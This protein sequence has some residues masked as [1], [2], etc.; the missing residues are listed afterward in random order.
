MAKT[1]IYI[2]IYL[3]KIS[4]ASRS[5]LFLRRYWLTWFH[6]KVVAP[7]HKLNET[8]SICILV[9]LSTT[10][11]GPILERSY[12]LVPLLIAGSVIPLDIIPT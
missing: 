11:P 5:A 12:C 3:K 9:A 2:F 7:M 10:S 1:N 8:Y 6:A 4:L